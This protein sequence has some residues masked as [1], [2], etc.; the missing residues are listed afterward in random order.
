MSGQWFP[1]VPLAPTEEEWAD[2]LTAAVVAANPDID[3]AD[4]VLRDVFRV[5]LPRAS[6]E[7]EPDCW[8]CKGGREIPIGPGPLGQDLYD[9]CPACD[10][11][12]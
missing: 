9:P 1:V 5:P 8:R 11:E 6:D 7:D 12:A 10:P 3:R 2:A 4:A